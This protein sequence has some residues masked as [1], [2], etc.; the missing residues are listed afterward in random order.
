MFKLLVVLNTRPSLVEPA[1]C[2]RRACSKKGK[3]RSELWS[4]N[5]IGGNYRVLRENTPPTAT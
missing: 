2:I 4:A 1:T 5:I 3:V